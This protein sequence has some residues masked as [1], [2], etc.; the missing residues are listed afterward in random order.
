MM[1]RLRF[2]Q[3]QFLTALADL[4]S[5]HRVAE[6]LGMTQPGATK[7]LR[8]IETTFGTQLFLRSKRGMRPNELGGCVVRY[9]RL[10]QSDLQQ[11]REEIAGVLTGKGGRLSVGAIGGAMPAVLV[12]ALTRLRAV[13]PALSVSVREDTSAGLLAALDE[14]RLDLAICRTTVSAEPDRYVYEALCDEQVVAAVGPGHPLAHAAE[15]TWRQLARYGWVFYPSPMPLRS[16]LE[17]EFKE[18]GLPLP[19]YTTETASIFVTTLL[20]QEDAHLVALL[21]AE[22][23]AFCRRHGL[24]HALPLAVR[25]RTEPYGIVTRRGSLLSPAA[26]LLAA[27]LRDVA[28]ERTSGVVAEATG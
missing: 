15:V 22:T 5:L 7:M 18:A 4:G 19:E 14:G 9:A 13:Q 3:L 28:R 6:Q 25:A 10:S 16:V 20:L 26:G 11:L 17:R 12:P 2:R 1:A 23:M 21:T 24:A 8:E 27:A